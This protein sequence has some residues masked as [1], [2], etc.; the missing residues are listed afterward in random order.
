M[1]NEP[2]A[3]IASFIAMAFVVIAYFVKKKGLYLLF[4]LL[5]IIFLV[6]SYF[7]E[8]KFF[9][10]IGLIVGLGR[11]TTFFIYEQKGKQ[12]P[13]FWP[14][15]FS[16]LT[17]AVYWI[18]NFGIQQNSS[19][20]DILNLFALVMYA[21]IFRIRDLKIV[22]FTMLAPTVLEIAFNIC[23]QSTIFAILVY[24]FEL[25]ANLVSIVKYHIIPKIKGE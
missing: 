1:V 13:I 6:V 2:L 12:A 10:M 5:C 24:V 23:V 20:Y 9:A 11:T 4:Q 17:I 21:F 7:F 14:F 16:G 15:L 25:G 8:A 19:P 22:R 3:L 18:V